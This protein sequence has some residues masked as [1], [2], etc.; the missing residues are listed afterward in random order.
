MSESLVYYY[1]NLT[2][3]VSIL[4]NRE[5]WMTN[6]RNL[7]DG[8][9]SIVAYKMFFELLEE[10]DEDNKL[11]SLWEFAMTPGAIQLYTKP[12]G[13]SPDFVVCFSKNSDSVAQWISYADDGQGI[14]IGFD[15]FELEQFTNNV[16]LKYHSITYVNKEDIQ[17]HVPSVYDYLVNNIESNNLC[18]MDKAMEIIF[19]LFPKTNSYKSFHY[20]SECERRIIYDYPTKITKLPGGWSIKNIDVYAKNN[21]MN[22]FIPLVF[23]N[24]AVK[25]I[26]TGPKY[27]ENGFEIHLALEVLGYYDVNVLHSTSG[28]R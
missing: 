17:K 20:S 12:L 28:Y 15:E 22:T 18:M 13:E 1:C 4:K 2:T 27:K 21:Q 14:A 5:I 19:Q 9:E 16:G 3:A 23:P 6:I 7:N 10:Y 25:E 11:S 24:T 8:N 26:I